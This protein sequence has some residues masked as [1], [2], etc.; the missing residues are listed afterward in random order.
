MVTAQAVRYHE[1]G[2]PEVLA[3]EEV[4]LPRPGAGQVRVAVRAAGVN[5]LD[6]KLRTG[7]RGTPPDGPQGT[8]IELA[9]T[10]DALG[11]GVAGLEVGQAVFGQVASGAAATYALA[12]AAALRPKPEHLSYAE[13]AA[14]PVALETAHR[15]LEE[16]GLR[17]GETLLVHAVAGGVGLAAA[18][19]ALAR[20][21]HVV[22]TASERHHAFLRELGVVPVTYGDGLEQRLPGPVDRVLDASGRGEVGLSVG[23]TGDPDKVLTIADPAGAAEH[24]VRF[25]TGK[26]GTFPAD[27]LPRVPVAEVFPLERA[28]DAHRRSQD[29]HF[30]GKLVLDAEAS[31]PR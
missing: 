27:V 19:V 18:Q 1:H 8:G 22:G 11:P 24:G 13:A 17:A 10:V 28:A 2:G 3:L 31:L 29:G 21:A 15:T 6:W 25:S 5:A 20:G 12:E 16:L 7:F 23:L 14:L 30:L 9:G 4:P 26:G